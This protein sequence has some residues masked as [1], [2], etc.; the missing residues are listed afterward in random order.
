MKR[1]RAL[2]LLAL[3]GLPL[4][5]CGTLIASRDLATSHD[6]ASGRYRPYEGVSLDGLG[7]YAAFADPSKFLLLAPIALVDLPLSFVADTVLLPI[8]VGESIAERLADKPQSIE[9]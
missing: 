5:G 2:A 1:L 8:P 3:L 6:M 7:F 9:R 4:S